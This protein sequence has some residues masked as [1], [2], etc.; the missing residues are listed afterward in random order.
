MA[1]ETIYRRKGIAE[2]ALARIRRSS[3]D[4]ERILEVPIES[5]L[6]SQSLIRSNF[7][8]T[9]E[10]RNG[11]EFQQGDVINEIVKQMHSFNVEKRKGIVSQ[12][13]T[14]M[15]VV[16]IPYAGKE[17]HMSCDNYQLHVLRSILPPGTMVTVTLAPDS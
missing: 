4:K 12:L 13:F 7:S 1:T 15:N 16:P 6:F 2:A 5:I 11:G 3:N 17:H 8:D 14:I 9:L 10:A